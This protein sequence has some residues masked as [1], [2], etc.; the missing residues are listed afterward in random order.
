MKYRENGLYDKSNT[1]FLSLNTSVE[2]SGCAGAKSYGNDFTIKCTLP[3][4]DYIVG[5]QDGPIMTLPVGCC[6][7]T[8]LVLVNV[9][10]AVPGDIH[11]YEFTS[12]SPKVTFSI[13]YSGYATF[14]QGGSGTIMTVANTNLTNY[15]EAVVKFKLINEN[16][17]IEN[18]EYLGLKCGPECA[19]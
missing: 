4:T 16:L 5:F 15:D 6:S 3:S 8:R 9:S 2:P 19:T 18:H 12:F 13:P 17:G 7:G 10:G 11:K 1:K 14:K